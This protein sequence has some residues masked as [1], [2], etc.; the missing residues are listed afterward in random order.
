LIEETLC[1]V[2]P[3]SATLRVDLELR[4]SPEGNWTVP[5]DFARLEK[6]LFHLLS[7]AVKYN[8]PGGKV[9][10]ECAP[11][12]AADP[13]AF[14]FSVQD[15]GPGISAGNLPRLFTPFDR[16]DMERSQGNVAGT[17]L[18][19][20]LSK[21]MVER[22][23]GQIGVASTLGKGSTFWIE[24][25]LVENPGAPAFIRSPPA[26]VPA[27]RTLLYMED[28][29][30]NLRLITRIVARRPAIQLLPAGTV[31][32]GLEMA[33]ERQP[34][35]ILLDLHFPESDGGQVLAQ[36]RA[37]PRTAEI[38]VVMLDEG[39]PGKREQVAAAGA[40]VFLTRPVEVRALLGVLD[41]F[42]DFPPEEAG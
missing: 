26:V 37:D 34:D 30:V 4:F 28:H 3:L 18:G 11:V 7:N 10:L 16:L 38:P 12:L 39:A 41:R 6:A 29:P 21:R 8:R 2:R 25:P 42:I 19:L 13:P 31:A 15:T 20:A 23:G 33:R 1:L 40:C 35:L 32:L 9:L 36:L 5:G 14:R 24:M 22:M 17:G 27:S